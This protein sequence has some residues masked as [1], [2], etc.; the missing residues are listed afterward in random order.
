VAVHTDK[1]QRGGRFLIGRQ[2]YPQKSQNRKLGIIAKMHFN[3][4]KFRFRLL[5]FLCIFFLF[6]F[7]FFLFF[8]S[9][10][11]FLSFFSFFF[12]F[13]FFFISFFSLVSFLAK[14]SRIRRG[15][16]FDLRHYYPI[17][18]QCINFAIKVS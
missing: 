10:Y 1:P 14:L 2:E 12:S 8:L 17:L 4:I 15:V 13:F 9:L 6:F 18:A 5:F 7:S 11:Y 3:L 16:I